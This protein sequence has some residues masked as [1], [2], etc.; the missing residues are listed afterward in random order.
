MQ[1]FQQQEEENT[2]KFTVSKAIRKAML[3]TFLVLTILFG[4][5][6]LWFIPTF[7]SHVKLSKLASANSNAI[8]ISKSANSALIDMD[9]NEYF[10]G[11]THVLCSER[12]RNI[13]D[14]KL[15]EDIFYEYMDKYFSD[16]RF[17][18]FIVIE[19]GKVTYSAAQYASQKMT[20]SYPNRAV[21]D[22]G[23]AFYDGTYKNKKADL[24]DLYKYVHD[25][26]N[27]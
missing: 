19:E 26:L 13:T 25:N 15:D 1:N 5:P 20:G 16:I 27:K 2:E 17:R 23:P 9:D 7:N 24:D 10:I 3:M 14:G 4:V 21:K 18:W 11:G 6:M 22:R 8:A 12:K